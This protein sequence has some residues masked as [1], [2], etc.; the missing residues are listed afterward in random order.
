MKIKFVFLSIVILLF[1]CRVSAVEY[2]P[3]HYIILVDQT[4]DLQIDDKASF[5]KVFSFIKNNL[6]GI[7][8][9]SFVF[10]ERTDEISLY[11][12]A[13]SG[14]GLMGGKYGEIHRIASSGNKERAYNVFVKNLIWN[15]IHYS[16]EREK[17]ISLET[18]INNNLRPLFNA[19]SNHF[20]MLA[21]ERVGAVT[22]SKYVFP[23]ILESEHFNFSTPASEYIII[24]ASNFQSGLDDI[25]TSQDRN[26]LIQM[27]G[28]Q[29]QSIKTNLRF[30]EEKFNTLADPFYQIPLFRKEFSSSNQR[31]NAQPTAL[32]Y[33][34]GLK[35]LQGVS[36]YETT[37]FL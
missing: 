37:S 35:S 4:K 6:E 36:T 16:N 34:L 14:D 31:K 8:D 1:N 30:F 26:T 27:L 3:R 20:R 32:G 17:G 33:K 11:T 5:L 22:F 12:F 18:F 23:T 29:D 21:N 24:I 7:G 2:Y 15:Q 19:E 13:L 25:G 28:E 9:Q 10:D